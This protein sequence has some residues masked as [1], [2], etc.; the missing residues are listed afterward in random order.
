M[1][2]HPPDTHHGAPASR[3]W[4][5]QPWL[6]AIVVL[7]SAIPLLWPDIPPLVD[8]PGHMGRFHVQLEIGRSPGLQRF[9]HF[10]WA[11]IG[12]LGV[13]LLVIPL[14]KIVGVEAAVKLITISIP[15][16]TTA[17]MLW[18]AREVHGR[19][20]PTTFFALPLAFNFPFMFGF[21]NFALSM[22]LALLAFAL[23]LRLARLGRLKLRAALFV[24]IS[25]LIWVAHTFGWGTL[26][27]MAFSAEFVRQLDLRRGFFNGGIKAAIQCISLAPPV[28]LMMAWRSGEHVTG[29]TGQ[30][31]KWTQKMNWVLM[32]LRD[33]WEDFDKGSL[34]VI[35]LVLVIGLLWWRRLQYS[36]NL[37]ASALFLAIVYICL[38]RI[39]FGS[40][41]ADMRLAPYAIAVAVIG[42]RFKRNWDGK[43]GTILAVL[44][45]VFVAV[46]TA[47]TTASFYLYDQAYDA[48]LKAVPH[49]PRDARL[50]SFVGVPCGRGWAMSRIEHLPAV[51]LVR[52]D[53][54]SNDQWSMH[55]AQLL[56]TRYP[57]GGRFA[58]DPYQQV[59]EGQCY[60]EIWLSLNRSLAEFPRNAYD[61][62]WLIRPP[63]HDPRLLRGL[64]PI[65]RSGTSVLYR[66]VDRTQPRIP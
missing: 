32:A 20:P 65:W 24:P 12:N 33:R 36:R 29:Y 18:V 4:W 52:R 47:G 8:L 27:V 2:A 21:L 7:V 17:G 63:R 19:I 35:G 28:L 45:L 10:E 13:D 49:I 57:Q 42:I 16:M 61:Y 30:W 46:R 51:A 37:A 50:L 59:L 60:G 62:V 9:Y 23:W 14:A 15:V 43:A 26:G 53:A 31:F 1:I 34:A 3:L 5:E 44:G 39:V 55:G 54:F 25:V 22:A 48:E 41:Y 38:P 40:N 56:T 64:Q 11:L 6:L 66:V 58:R